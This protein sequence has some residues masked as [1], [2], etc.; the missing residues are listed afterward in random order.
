MCLSLSNITNYD[1]DVR[2]IVDAENSPPSC[3]FV[4]IT[5]NY[6]FI[7]DEMNESTENVKVG[8]AYCI[9]TFCRYSLR[10]VKVSS[11]SKNSYKVFLHKT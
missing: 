4:T 10:L 1:Y 8:V 11:K 2:Y 7:A 5:T 6:K 3:N 9:Q